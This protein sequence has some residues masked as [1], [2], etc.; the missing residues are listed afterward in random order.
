MKKIK[1]I[2]VFLL[3]LGLLSGMSYFSSKTIFSAYARLVRYLPDDKSFLKL[4]PP[5]ENKN[6]LRTL[7]Y[8][9]LDY[10]IKSLPWILVISILVY[11]IYNLIT[12]KEDNL[13]KNN[14][15]NSIAL[16]KEKKEKKSLFKNPD[17]KLLD[18]EISKLLNRI[19]ELENH[20]TVEFVRKDEFDENLAQSLRSICLSM[21]MDLELMKIRNLDPSISKF[22]INIR[23]FENLISDLLFRSRILNGSLIFKEEDFFIKELLYSSLEANSEKIAKK[24]IVVE[25]H[26]ED[27]IASGDYDL[28]SDALARIINF[29]CVHASMEDRISFRVLDKDSPVLEIKT[30]I[31]SKKIE[32]LEKAFSGIYRNDRLKYDSLDLLLAK[33]LFDNMGGS[34]EF[35][36]NPTGSTLFIKL[37]KS[38]AH[39]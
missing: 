32:N 35:S 28:A 15:Q 16:I 37:K 31:G 4:Q 2:W 39:A 11:I 30:D 33:M 25:N 8:S 26:I 9:P 36:L 3:S 19:D 1:N 17:F 14:V 6:F 29:L 27:Q 21:V 18:R 22:E 24:K 13:V 38:Q 23:A 5:V 7:G 34:I 10:F 20:K 12:S